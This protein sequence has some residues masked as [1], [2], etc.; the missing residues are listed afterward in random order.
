MSELHEHEAEAEVVNL[1]DGVDPLLAQWARFRPLFV[2]ALAG[3]AYWTV[4][5]LEQRIAHRRAFF[6][7]GHEAAIVGEVE[8]YPTGIRM[9]RVFR[10][11][12]DPAGG[13]QMMPGV[14]AVARM[15]GCD[16][17][18]VEGRPTATLPLEA[19]GYAPF[20]STVGKSL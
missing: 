3:D 8:V 13:V 5:D 6:F 10:F 2:E 19:V 15:M 14:E 11:V 20:V 17:I 16:G 1:S 12:G 18:L 9:F 4:E 7:P